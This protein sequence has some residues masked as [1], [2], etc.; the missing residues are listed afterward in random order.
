MKTYRVIVVGPT[1]AGKSQFCNF[2]RRDT[3]NSINKVSDSLD[4]CT[5]DP[6]CNSF[7]RNNAN[8]EF[9]DT[10]GSADS[11]DN[12]V[13]NLEK[14][15]EFLKTKQ[16][17]EYIILLLKFNERV[18]K[19]TRNYIET[20]GKIFTPAEFYSHLCVFFTKYPIHASKKEEKIKKKSIEEIN[21]ILKQTFNVNK[22]IQ[23][24]DVKVYFVDTEVD[25]EEGTYEE[26]YQET[27]DIMMEQMKLDVD[28]NQS[29]NTKD[30]DATGHNA[31]IRN[32]EQIKRIKKLYEE[33]K[34]KRED[35]EKEKKRLEKEIQKSK[36]NDLERKKKEKELN[37]LIEKQKLEKARI[38]EMEKENIR[39]QKLIEE[40]AKKK[41]IE[42]ERLDNII[43]GCGYLAKAQGITAGASF[44]L[45][46][47]GIALTAV[48]PVAGPFIAATFLG[49]SLGCGIWTAGAG[50][51]A[52]GA[53][54]AKEIKK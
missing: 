54:I 34:K 19:D 23:I 32:D 6:F 31:K 27:I 48:C 7:Q 16:Q 35:E 22:N 21:N 43:D 51:V 13:R 44:L 38:E 1:G 45:G 49:G 39:K 36:A 5:Q 3:T 11:S 26:K 18:T 25:E 9:I 52:A 42:I 30:L 4:S 33:E 41:G 8:Y 37:E 50:V 15:V 46:L 40:E 28:I 53:K 29:I 20:L 2:V 14:L 12:D 17:I 24:P 10:A 47:G